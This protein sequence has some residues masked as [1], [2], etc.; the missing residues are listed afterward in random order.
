MTNTMTKIIKQTFFTAGEDWSPEEIQTAAEEYNKIKDTLE[1]VAQGKRDTI[2]IAGAAV[3]IYEKHGHKSP[4]Y[5]DFLNNLIQTAPGWSD[6]KFR[7]RAVAAYRGYEAL[8]GSDAD[9][10][11][12]WKLNPSLSALT[13][14][15]N[16]HPS[17]QHEFRKAIKNGSKFP[18]RAE[19]AS[20]AKKGYLPVPKLKE[21]TPALTGES[22]KVSVS[23]NSEAT[24]ATE[25]V[26]T[27][28]VTVYHPEPE[29]VHE[30]KSTQSYQSS[31]SPTP[32]NKDPVVRDSVN[33]P[34]H[35]TA[36]SVDAKSRMNTMKV[37][38]SD[39]LT[40]IAETF[41]AGAPVVNDPNTLNALERLISAYERL[42]PNQTIEVNDEATRT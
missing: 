33:I 10:E 41:E 4:L 12:I 30:Y 2:V 36:N 35:R 15:Q 17:D 24:E 11:F 28:E 5:R 23:S 19:V 40:Y 20:F 25:V 3:R 34:I 22:E 27:P 42:Q 7:E 9:K 6:Q 38:F 39:A 32:V 29:E 16:I 13:E 31:P 1:R 37:R 21:E 26:E 14:C 18:T 8:S